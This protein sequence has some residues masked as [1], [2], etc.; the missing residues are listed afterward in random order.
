MNDEEAIVPDAPGELVRRW[1]DARERGDVAALRDLTAGDAVWESPVNGAVHGR[2]RLV[3]QVAAAW[4][5]TDA[6]S[7]ETRSLE[8][9]DGRAA[10]IVRNSGRRDGEVLDSLQT[11]FITAG[12]DGV[13]HVRVAVDDPA[14]VDAFWSG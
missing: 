4:E 2:D 11:L 7:T 10:A 5:D 9:R 14:A 13:R 6:F 8:V 12:D 3:A 1:L